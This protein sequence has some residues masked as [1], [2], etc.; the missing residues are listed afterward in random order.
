METTQKP[1]SKDEKS[2]GWDSKQAHPVHK[3]TVLPLHR[4]NGCD[5][6]SLGDGYQSA[7]LCRG[8]DKS[9]AFLIS[10]TGGLRHNQ[11][12]FS[13]MSKGSSNNEVISTWSSVGICT[14]NTFF[15]I[16]QLVVFFIKPKTYQP[17][18]YTAL[19]H[20]KP[21]TSIHMDLISN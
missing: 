19:H 21:Y 8:A 13:W 11:K 2:A 14:V 15:S 3:S 7:K 5:A 18:S 9:L 16:L 10:P 1:S 12:N 6:I 4:P 20:G 17:P